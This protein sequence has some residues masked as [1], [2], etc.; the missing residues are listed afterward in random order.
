MINTPEIVKNFICFEPE[1]VSKFQCDGE[2]CGAQCCTGFQ[3]DI[4]RH[5][6]FK[7]RSIKDQDV[8]RKILDSLFWNQDSQTYRMKLGENA[9]C[10]MICDGHLCFIQKT[11]GEDFLSNI[12]AEFP[13]RTYVVGDAVTRT[14]SLNCPIAA[15]IA[16]IDHNSMQFQNVEIRT[17]RAGCFFYRAV[18][19]V[20]TR[21]FLIPLQKIGIE[22]L[23]NRKY[24]VNERLATLG[25]AMSMVDYQI[26][27]LSEEIIE[28]FAEKFRTQDFF[29]TMQNNFRIL[30]FDKPDYLQMMFRLLDELFGTAIIYYS[31]EQRNFVQY[32]P[33]AFGVVE[34]TSKSLEEGYR[35]YD[36]NFAAYD[37]FVRKPYPQLMENYLA[38]S[39]FAGLYPCRLPGNLMF[40]YFLFA[41]IYKFFEFSLICMAGVLREKLTLDDILGLIGRFSFRIDHGALFQKVT[42]DYFQQL[43]SYPNELFNALIDFEN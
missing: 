13:R 25:I 21:K 37:E 1:Y 9:V 3:V 6:H 29:D 18:S 20:P 17:T 7:Y 24:T 36:E 30:K 12:C 39:F 5:T 42:L 16:L 28:E 43:L 26:E 22:I 15:K 23:Q 31:E 34:E 41:A 19:D 38:H 10:P 11:F 35:L 33:Q 14:L 2:I 4:D 8:R 27:N 40:N 32:I